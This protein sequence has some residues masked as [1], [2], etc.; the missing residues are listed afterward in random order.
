MKLLSKQSDYALQLVMD[1]P[2]KHAG[3]VLSIRDFCDSRNL[4]FAFMQRI[5]RSL[6]IAGIVDSVRGANGGYYLRAS[7]SELQVIDIIRAVEPEF[8]SAC[9]SGCKV[10]DSC[11]GKGAM[12]MIEKR[13]HD[14]LHFSIATMK[15]G[16]C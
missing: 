9:A 16:V 8:V 11:K 1:L 5:V 13:V 3:T 14:A 7:I 4:S 12:Q 15:Q 6:R 10:A 2:D